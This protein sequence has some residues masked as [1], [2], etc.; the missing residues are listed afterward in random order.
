MHGIILTILLLFISV[1]AI[2]QELPDH[3][4]QVNRGS[5]PE[6]LLRPVRGET[7]HFPID[8]VIGELGRGD[9]SEDAYYFASSICQAF[10]DQEI[11]H[12][13][14][15]SVSPELLENYLSMLRVIEPGSFRIGGGREEADGSVSFLVRFIGREQAITGELYVRQGGRTANNVDRST[16]NWEF[17]ELLLE[18]AKNRDTEHQESI[19]RH[20]FNP[21]ERF[22]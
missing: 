12:S 5:I 6:A 13:V 4:E 2:S 9:A 10:L 22:F 17:D 14:L 7:A 11:N 16:G 15:S 18:E 20:D 3:I 1:F 21:Y 8:M 19:H